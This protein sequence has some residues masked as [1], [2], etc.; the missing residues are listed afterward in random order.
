[1]ARSVYCDGRQSQFPARPRLMA[2]RSPQCTK[3]EA[4]LEGI[5]YVV[6]LHRTFDMFKFT[7]VRRSAC[8]KMPGRGRTGHR[9]F[10]VLPYVTRVTVPLCV[11][12]IRNSVLVVV[13]GV[14]L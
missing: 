11:L 1:M 10:L 8:P 5:S 12:S 4:P 9:G 3:R 7:G 14:S 6:F 2:D 13:F